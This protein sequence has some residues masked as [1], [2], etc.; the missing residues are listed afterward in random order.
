M[1]TYDILDTEEALHNCTKEA[2]VEISSIY[3]QDFRE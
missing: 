1:R 3:D 2:I